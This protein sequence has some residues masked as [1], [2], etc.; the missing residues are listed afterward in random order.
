MVVAHEKIPAGAAASQLSR[1]DVQ[2]VTGV[3]VVVVATGV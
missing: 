1:V 3:E 2:V